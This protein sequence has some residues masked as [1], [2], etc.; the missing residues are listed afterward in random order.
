MSAA[1][2]HVCAHTSMALAWRRTRSLSRC[3]SPYIT[4]AATVALIVRREC[5]AGG[6]REGEK[7]KKQKEP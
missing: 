6:K 4:M 5:T 7:I 3:L 1:R 2:V